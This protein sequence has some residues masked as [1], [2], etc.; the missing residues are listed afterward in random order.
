VLKRIS[1]SKDCKRWRV[2]IYFSPAGINDQK[3][4]GQYLAIK[5]WRFLGIK[6]ILFKMRWY[7][8]EPLPVKLD[9]LIKLIDEQAKIGRVS[10]VAAS[11]GASAAINAFALRPSTIHRVICLC[12]AIKG[13][14]DIHPLTFE[15]NPAFKESIYLVPASLEKLDSSARSR[16]LS[17]H[18]IKDS[19]VPV[20][21]TYIEGAKSGTMPVFGHV[22]G[23]MYGLLIG[24]FRAKRFIRK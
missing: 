8:D 24:I 20:R 19:W 10:L 12:G 5:T 16:I 17:L 13:I 2:K 6:P 18:P 7:L 11:A 4:R 22:V 21:N 14:E 9:E 15:K 1:V 3:V 23:I